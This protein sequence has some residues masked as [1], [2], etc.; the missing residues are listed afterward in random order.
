MALAVRC[1]YRTCRRYGKW[2]LES[3]SGMAQ[4][5]VDGNGGYFSVVAGL[6][7]TTKGVIANTRFCKEESCN[8]LVC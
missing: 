5:N 4:M 6:M 1:F 2:P 7:I 8:E 3:A